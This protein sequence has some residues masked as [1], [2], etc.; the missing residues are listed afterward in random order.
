MKECN[1][2]FTTFNRRHHC[3]YCGKLVC[4]KCSK[5]KLASK[6]DHKK[7]VKPVCVQCFNTWGKKYQAPDKGEIEKVEEDDD[8]E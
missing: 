7:I 1:T 3:R 5:Y 4:G 8:E 2:K 6:K